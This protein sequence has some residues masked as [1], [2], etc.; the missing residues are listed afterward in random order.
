V[1]GRR[2]T[3]R[4]YGTSSEHLLP[5]TPQAPPAGERASG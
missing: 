3:C 5:D 4:R 2:R 1:A